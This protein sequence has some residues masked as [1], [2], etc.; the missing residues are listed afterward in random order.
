MIVETKRLIFLVSLQTL[1]HYRVTVLIIDPQNIPTLLRPLPFHLERPGPHEYISTVLRIHPNVEQVLAE[2][3][4]QSV[5][6]DQAT[7]FVVEVP[8]EFPG[9]RVWDNCFVVPASQHPPYEILPT[10]C[11][12]EGGN[13]A[14]LQNVGQLKET[15][16]V[17][18]YFEGK[19]LKMHLRKL[20]DH[21]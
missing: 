10:D 8:V 14:E 17:E 7:V 18:Q 4:I 16:Y 6:P 15:Q 21:C 13:S 19:V 9:V 12:E 11:F 20:L 5:H 3:S 1:A 2:E